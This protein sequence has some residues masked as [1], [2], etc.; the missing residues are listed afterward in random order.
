MS[1]KGF[2]VWSI[3]EKEY[4]DRGLYED[5]I[6]I[7]PDGRVMWHYCNEDGKADVED[8][9]DKVRVDYDDVA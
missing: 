4:Y 9:S 7:L 5:Q 6:E 1:E 2:K 8:I 3:E